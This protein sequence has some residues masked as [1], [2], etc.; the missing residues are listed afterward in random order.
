M[1]SHRKKLKDNS[2]HS[3][4]ELSGIIRKSKFRHSQYYISV[5]AYDRNWKG[6]FNE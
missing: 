2:F 4:K 3:N 5:D 6:H 1:I